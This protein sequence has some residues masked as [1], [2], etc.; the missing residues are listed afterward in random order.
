[1]MDSG[2]AG[3]SR[4]WDDGGNDSRTSSEVEAGAL[5]GRMTERIRSRAASVE[6]GIG[7]RTTR[8]IATR[9]QHHMTISDD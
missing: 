4:R 8:T 1:M 7:S 3:G 2:S 6:S 5:H 9:P